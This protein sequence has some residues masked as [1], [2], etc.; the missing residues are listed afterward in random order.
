MRGVGT[1]TAVSRRQSFTFLHCFIYTRQAVEKRRRR[2][3]AEGGRS[4]SAALRAQNV[5]LHRVHLKPLPWHFLL[6]PRGAPPA[7]DW[8]P[9]DVNMWKISGLRQL[10]IVINVRIHQRMFREVEKTLHVTP[11][12]LLVLCHGAEVL[13]LIV[14]SWTGSMLDQVARHTLLNLVDKNNFWLKH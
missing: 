12:C 3:P 10:K 1:K 5:L 7:A 9:D 8:L 4:S 11:R 6:L 14:T 13:D 2:I